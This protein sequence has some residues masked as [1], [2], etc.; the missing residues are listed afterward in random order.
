MVLGNTVD[1]ERATNAVR[2]HG[3]P[4]DD[5]LRHHRSPLGWESITLTGDPLWRSSAN[6]GAGKFG[7]LR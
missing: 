5:A 1:R 7:P 6:V 3:Q 2:G 4:V